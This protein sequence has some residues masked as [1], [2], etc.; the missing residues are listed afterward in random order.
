[1]A[2]DRRLRGRHGLRRQA[3]AAAGSTDGALAMAAAAGTCVARTVDAGAGSFLEN[4]T[5]PM[6]IRKA[7][8]IIV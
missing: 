5:T 6:T 7:I 8:G 4:M 3:G 1:L 2:L